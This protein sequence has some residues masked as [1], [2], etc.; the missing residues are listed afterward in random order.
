MGCCGA[1]GIAA[2]DG[3][4]AWGQELAIGWGAGPGIGAGLAG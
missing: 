3:A 1:C 4:G 2:V